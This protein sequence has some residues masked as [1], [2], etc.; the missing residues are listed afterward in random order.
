[1]YG[2]R[3]ARWV[4]EDIDEGRQMKMAMVMRVTMKGREVGRNTSF[5]LFAYAMESFSSSSFNH[6]YTVLIIQLHI[7]RLNAHNVVCASLSH[8]T[9]FTLLTPVSCISTLT[10]REVSYLGIYTS[11]MDYKNPSIY[12]GISAHMR[13][14]L[15]LM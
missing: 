2:S 10:C 11:L 8:I 9:G 3:L 13:S 12:M 15:L 5:R 4:Q 14:A 6:T 7:S 1:V